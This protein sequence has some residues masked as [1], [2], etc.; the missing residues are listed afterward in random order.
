MKKKAP[1]AKKPDAVYSLELCIEIC[2]RVSHGENIKTVLESDER[3]PHFSTFCDWK[4][5]KAELSDLYARAREN[6]AEMVD[7][8]MDRIMADL[9]SGKIN[10]N[11]ARVLIDTLKWKAS[12]YYP[13]MYGDKLDVTSDGQPIDNKFEY[14]VVTNKK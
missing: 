2:K 7:S 1:E 10:P 6:K 14:T 13:K 8:E 11:A 9:E 3:F 12:K 5:E 4:R